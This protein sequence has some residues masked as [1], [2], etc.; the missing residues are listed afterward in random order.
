MV[1]EKKVKSPASKFGQIIGE[2][3]EEDVIEFVR[4]YLAENMPV[5]NS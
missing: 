1:S 4:Q 3:F 5:M 2:V